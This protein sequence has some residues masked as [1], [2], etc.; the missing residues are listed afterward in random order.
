[1][2]NNANPLK[3]FYRIVKT[4]VRLPSRGLFYEDGVVDLNDE[5][6]VNILPMTAADELILKNPDALLSGQ[7][8]LEVI[9]SCVPAVK[10]P[11][12]L[13]SCDIDTL[14]VGIRDAS[15]GDDSTME[16]KCPSCGAQNTYGLNLEIL[17][18][19]TEFLK[20]SYSVDLKDDLRVYVRPG[21]FES[22]IKQQKTLL[23]NK[24]IENILAQDNISED[25]K[26]KLFAAVFNK[27]GRL[28]Y[29][30][31]LDSVVRVDITQE[32]GNVES[33]TNKAHIED[34]LKNIDKKQVDKIEAVIR[35]SNSV[36]IQDKIPAICTSCGH[37]WDAPIEFNPVNF[38]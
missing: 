31:V 14:M 28:N 23:D 16:I 32:D 13:L 29:E 10:K 33:V 2:S 5:Y 11:T 20:E 12:K 30:L 19:Q 18:N 15:Y 22:V 3:K 27:L 8:I 4:T 9:K 1:M 21:T 38:S 36:G 7:A 37:E 17:L 34:F 35:E 26:L 24:R 25:E 6:E